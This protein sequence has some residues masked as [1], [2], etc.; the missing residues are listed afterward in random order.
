MSEE[1]DHYTISETDSEVDQ[2]VS[3]NAA[4]LASITTFDYVLGIRI[5]LPDPTLW[6]HSSPH[7]TRNG[8][9]LA[10]LLPSWTN[11]LSHDSSEDAIAEDSASDLYDE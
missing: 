9:H 2:R 5:L 11:M 1:G 6:V 3:E 4:L 8:H 10:L 7:H